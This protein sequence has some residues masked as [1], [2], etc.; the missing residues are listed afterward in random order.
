MY[1]TN[2]CTFQRKKRKL[3]T[4][5]HEKKKDKHQLDLERAVDLVYLLHF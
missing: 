4:R 2:R 3:L 1:H 5:K